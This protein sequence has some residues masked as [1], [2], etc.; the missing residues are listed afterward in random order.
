[1]VLLF[2]LNRA[3][4][5]E[6]YIRRVLTEILGLTIFVDVLLEI[7]IF[8][9]PVELLLVPTVTLLA[10]I[11]AWNAQ[12]PDQTAAAGCAQAQTS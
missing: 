7:S 3:T 1:L 6:R 9:L 10:V 8:A 11:Q 2:N 12:Q 5:E 4:R